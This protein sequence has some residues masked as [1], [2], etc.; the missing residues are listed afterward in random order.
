MTAVTL[1]A[2]WLRMMHAGEP[3]L[4]W[5]EFITVGSSLRPLPEMLGVLKHLGPTDTG[6]E[7]FPPLAHV[8]T[9]ILVQIARDDFLLRLPGIL[10][11]TA[12][13]PATWFLCR[14]P[15]GRLG[16]HA[17][18]VLLA[19]GVYHL[20]YSREVRPY[21]LFLLENVLALHFL[22]S[23]LTGG[24][25]R[26][27]WAWGAAVAAMLYTSYMA[28]TLVFAQAAF[29][30]GFLALQWKRGLRR[31]A[32]ETGWRAA[33]ALALAGAAYLPWAEG[34]FLVFRHLHDPGFKAAFSLDFIASSLQ[35]FA[36]F[37]YKGE[38]AAGWLL[39]GLAA[40][41]AAAA[42]AGGKG[43]FVLLLALW[44]F[45]PVA[46]V[47][48][49]KARMELTSRYFLTV[50]YL[51]AVFAGHF[52]AWC[53]NRLGDRLFGAGSP[54][55]FARLT[56]AA[57]LAV[58]VSAPNLQSLGGYYSR[59]TSGYKDLARYLIE[60]RDNKDMIVFLNP[61]N[62]KLIYDWY[63]QGG[64]VP[65][66]SLDV[67]GYR[68]AFLLAPDTGGAP[69]KAPA[70]VFNARFGDADILSM[71]IARTPV[72][73]MVPDAGGRF[74][75]VENFSGFRALEEAKLLENR[76][77]SPLTK[78]LTRHDAG[79]PARAVYAFKAP[80]GTGIRSA[81]LKVSVSA[82]LYADH[83]TDDSLAVSLALP[84]QGPVQLARLDMDA[85]RTQDGGLIPANHEKKR[86]ASADLDLTG[87]LAG[88][89]EFE[90]R[91]ES[92]SFT[93]SGAV[94]IEDFAVTAELDGPIPARDALPL[95]LLAQLPVAPYEPGVD[96]VL[97][98]FVH[99]FSLDGTVSAPGVGGPEL[100]KK[101]LAAHPGDKPVRVLP[102]AD[103]T[104][105]VALHDPALA[106]PWLRLPSG[107]ERLLE[108]TPPPGRVIEAV[109]VSG[110]LENPVL[111]FG[112]MSVP[113]PVACPA[114]ARLTVNCN[115]QAELEFTPL[116][117]AGEFDP[118]AMSAVSGARRNPGEDCLSCEGERECSFTYT[119]R[120]GLP[121]VSVH[122]TAYPRVF[123]DARGRYGV[124][125]Q[126]SADGGP[127][128][129]VNTYA[130]SGSGRW[131]G[132]K[133]PQ[134][135][136]VRLDVPAREVRVR[137]VLT[138]AKAQLWSAPDARMRLALRLDASSLPAPMVDTWPIGLSAANPA[139][140][141][142]LL[143]ENGQPFPDR[144]SRTR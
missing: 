48:L 108:A 117:T 45:M 81:R 90:L 88:A 113:L 132:L 13:I 26:M 69:G 143:L 64:P 44:A 73:P 50:Y 127:W 4:W 43:R 110:A 106:N 14:K 133:T 47:L 49:A 35:E 52:L 103:G 72:V 104:P 60:N 25:K 61:R 118:A 75:Y 125:T 10:A 102:Y 80:D 129:T 33:A 28:A 29:A 131:E 17:A 89:G 96:I 111:R 63:G 34:Q 16:A 71:G 95:A 11:G 79:L 122:L 97:S 56:A 38:F 58:A 21:S 36:A 66:R 126:V 27:L 141:D 30:A 8:F 121:V 41:G 98:R 91:F 68:R 120:S 65:A 138:G 137:F 42:I 134:Y 46:G 6:T 15:L 55:P 85:F 59:E 84:G 128:R 112:R 22:Y 142:I 87:L 31:E 101:Y 114:P 93:R 116:F 135:S 144:L 115:R 39:A 37:A 107:K 123:A 7:L 109:K 20:H 23:A 12:L 124:S 130:G 70:A 78:T 19:L 3:S 1:L 94:E 76:T 86:F 136:S 82:L 67:T 83:P 51:L 54:V 77:P 40:A 53:V 105:A 140:L 99:A 74:A 32:L 24:R 62:Q 9:H 57:L 5:D 92:P 119:V 139:P 2:A 100:L 18:C